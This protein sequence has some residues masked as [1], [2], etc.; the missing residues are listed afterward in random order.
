MYKRQVLDSQDLAK[1]VFTPKKWEL[2]K[3][4]AP[5]A[6]WKDWGYFEV[7]T[8][9]QLEDVILDTDS[10]FEKFQQGLMAAAGKADE[11]TWTRLW[12]AC[13]S[14]VKRKFKEISVG[15]DQYYMKVAE[16][17]NE[18]V[19]RTQVVDSVLHRTQIMRSPST[20]NK[21]A[22]AFMG[23]PSKTYNLLRTVS[24]THLALPTNSRV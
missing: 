15:S 20:L 12:G 13:E 10:R 8:G 7:N 14:Y 3:R 1:G 16:K 24:Y 6:Q 9:R 17:F 19:D 18:V 23:E 11:V 5:I 2:V 21:M 4:W 22:S